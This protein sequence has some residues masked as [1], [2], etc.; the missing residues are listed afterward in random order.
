MRYIKFSE[1]KKLANYK[2]DFRELQTQLWFK[3]ILS[4]VS[5]FYPNEKHIIKENMY[6]N[7]NVKISEPLA[8]YI[9]L[10]WFPELSSM[11]LYGLISNSINL[12]IYDY[13]STNV[14]NIISSD[15]TTQFE[16]D[17]KYKYIY[18]VMQD[19]ANLYKIGFTSNPKTRLMDIQI[20]NGRDITYI[21][22]DQVPDAQLLESNL[23]EIY[24]NKRKVGEW[25]ELS[26]I[27]IENILD[28]IN[29]WNS[30]YSNDNNKQISSNKFLHR[31]C[32]ECNRQFGVYKSDIMRGKG[33]FCSVSCSAKHKRDIK[34]K[35]VCKLCN[36]EFS[37][38]NN[39]LEFCS[40]ECE[41]F[42]KHN[43]KQII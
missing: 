18:V 13:L 26:S 43:L 41:L 24:K 21:I 7:T 15:R 9:L 16:S 8:V 1:L 42:Y 30:K 36:G 40:N 19:D 32:E 4:G 10:R 22:C 6:N 34:Y 37:T 12:S 35:K 5:I 14:S 17:K 2:T 27:D 38:L 29:N 28:Y 31:R 25:F 20:A 33:L 39:E 3:N 11:L 23:H